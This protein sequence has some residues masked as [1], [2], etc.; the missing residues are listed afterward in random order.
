[1]T[2]VV[3]CALEEIIPDEATEATEATELEFELE[4][5][6]TVLLMALML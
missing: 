3:G 6:L 4:L 1:M 2:V 5:E